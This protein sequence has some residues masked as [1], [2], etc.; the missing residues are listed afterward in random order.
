MKDLPL[1]WKRTLKQCNMALARR[2]LAE[3]F[4]MTDRDAEIQGKQAVFKTEFVDGWNDFAENPCYNT[5]VAWFKKAPD[6]APMI[7]EY[8]R[9]CCPGGRFHRIGIKT[10]MSFNLGDYS[11]D[12][13]LASFGKLIELTEREYVHF[14]RQLPGEAIY[15]AP[16]T[17]FL[18]Y[19]WDMMI[20][21]VNEEVYKLGA[22]LDIED[23]WQAH[24]LIQS[25]LKACEVQLGTPSEEKQGF[26][27]WDTADG[28]V[29]LQ[30]ASIMGTVAVNIYVT[31]RDIIR[32]TRL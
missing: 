31:S 10:A 28:N 9:E 5:A 21:M 26:F 32:K 4:Q 6:Y 22:S 11:L 19:R 23:Q 25:A 17:E 30:T 20:G 8:F 2:E 13:P 1:N 14:P 24:D 29:I 27:V 15:H 7:F 18:G 3:F 16:P 12:M